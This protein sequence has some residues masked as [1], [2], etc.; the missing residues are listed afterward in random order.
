MLFF[1]MSCELSTVLDISLERWHLLGV[2][3]DGEVSHGDD[4]TYCVRLTS[5]HHWFWH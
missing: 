5:P 4:G 1:Q 2:T 3:V